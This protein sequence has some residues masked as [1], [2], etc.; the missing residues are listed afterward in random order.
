M[1]RLNKWSDVAIDKALKMAGNSVIA[2]VP[3]APYHVKVLLDLITSLE[4]ELDRRQSELADVM[5][6]LRRARGE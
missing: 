4:D 6:K 1:I 3:L 5:I 2:D